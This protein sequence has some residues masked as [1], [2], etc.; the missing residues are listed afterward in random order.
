[1]LSTVLYNLLMAAV[2]GASLFW[3][4]RLRT[5]WAW[6]KAGVDTILAALALAVLLGPVPGQ[7]A[8]GIFR[9]LGF[10]LFL[11]GSVMLVGS[12]ML[13]RRARPKTAVVSLVMTFLGAAIVIDAFLI[14]PTWLDVTHV[15]IATTKISRPVRIVILADLQTDEI[16]PYERDVFRR[17]LGEQPDLIF[18]A[19]DHLQTADSACQGL[20]AEL[21]AFLREI[22]FSA[23]DGV[24]AVRGNV[25]PDDWA[26][27]FD[28]LPIVTVDARRSFDVGQLQLTCL[29][30]RESFNRWLEIPRGDPKRFHLVLGHAPSFA[31]GRIEA[32][33]LIAGHTHGGQ[34]CLPLL[35]PLVTP[36]RLPRRHSA[37]LLDLP[38]GAKIFISRGIGMER[39]AAPRLRFCCRPEL[40]VIELVP[41]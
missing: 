29:T 37:G 28:G 6:V 38:G 19:G 22:R 20:R 8:F 31:M 13:L 24:F 36:S 21:N 26:E 2:V 12:A 3:L 14:E 11:H 5:T 35:G 9:L 18:L 10:G 16:G 39:L 7:T 30:V 27:M 1:M 23:P 25:D 32:D 33:L 40:T 34:V 4:S 17:A 41:Q 15:R